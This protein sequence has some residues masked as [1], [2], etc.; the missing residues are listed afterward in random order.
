MRN[1]SSLESN[2]TTKHDRPI[3]CESR[4]F[5]LLV[6]RLFYLD[7]FSRNVGQRCVLTVGGGDDDKKKTTRGGTTKLQWDCESES[8]WILSFLDKTNVQKAVRLEL[9]TTSDQSG[10]RPTVARVAWATWFVT[11]KWLQYMTDFT[12]RLR[13]NT[14]TDP[15]SE[16]GKCKKII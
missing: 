13:I 1:G 9:L 6:D 7:S 12:N 15:K 11:Y 14:S 10:Q 5:F 2:N 8:R 16:D 4:L 3:P